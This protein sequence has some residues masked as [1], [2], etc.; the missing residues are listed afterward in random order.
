[1]INPVSRPNSET[2]CVTT[3][4]PRA[5]AM[6]GDQQVA[7][8]DGP[9]DTLQLEAQAGILV[10][11]SVINGQYLERLQERVDLAASG[12]SRTLSGRRTRAPQP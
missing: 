1:M 11:C 12:S 4:R 5:A 3:I 9:A 2:L 7:L 6:E 10:G 8:A